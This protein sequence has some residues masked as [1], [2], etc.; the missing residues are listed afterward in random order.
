MKHVLM[1]V[2]E[3][4]DEGQALDQP[5]LKS[6]TKRGAYFSN[7]HAVAHPSLPNYLALVGGD[8]FGLNDSNETDSR[9]FS[10]SERNLADS[11]EAA[12][13]TW[14]SYAEDYPGNC[15]LD[16][17]NGDYARR[18]EPFLYFS[19]ITSNLGRCSNIVNANQ[20]LI[21]LKNSSLPNFALYIPNVKNDGH[22][23]GVATADRWLKAFLDPLLINPKLMEELL[24]VVLFDE[25]DKNADNRV[26]AAFLGNG[27]K[28]GV[29]STN[30]Y[31]HLDLL[32]T[33]EKLFHADPVAK[34]GTQGH[35]I[36]D[37]WR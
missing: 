26:Y 3:N 25:S 34:E 29:Q 27:V 32:L 7:Y 15:F 6:L 30:C 33:V 13:K 14:K 8:T 21:D 9:Q 4:A 37:I 28:P 16:L 20:F 35:V 23:T 31:T 10:F 22:D 1:I 5:Y 12:G 2:L 11:L 18:H 36:R 17:H 19:S 24:V